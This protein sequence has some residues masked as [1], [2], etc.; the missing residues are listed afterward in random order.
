MTSGCLNW[1]FWIWGMGRIAGEVGTGR[2]H[3]VLTSVAAHMRSV[4]V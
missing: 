4:S 3:T 2:G 1:D